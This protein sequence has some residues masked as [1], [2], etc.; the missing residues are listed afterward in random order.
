[1]GGGIGEAGKLA[2][3]DLTLRFLSQQAV[4][5]D[6]NSTNYI[7]FSPFLF[8]V[9]TELNVQQIQY[10]CICVGTRYITMRESDIANMK[11]LRTITCTVNQKMFLSDM[12]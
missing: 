9:E 2:H 11:Q 10:M 1:M 7:H 4:T 8:Y 12:F 6:H 5:F 3:A